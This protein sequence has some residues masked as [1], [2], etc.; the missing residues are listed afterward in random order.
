MWAEEI[1]V[2]ETGVAN[3]KVSIRALSNSSELL[4]L[5]NDNLKK[6]TGMH[7]LRVLYSEHTENEKKSSSLIRIKV[8]YNWN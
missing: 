1:S 7:D 4:Q 3:W 8:E 2:V 6:K 5:Y